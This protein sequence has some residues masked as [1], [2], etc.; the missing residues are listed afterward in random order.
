MPG[1]VRPTADPESAPGPD[2]GGVPL[3]QFLLRPFVLPFTLLLGVG[4]AVLYGVTQNDAALQ[5]VLASQERAQLID[6]LTQQVSAME[7]AERGFVITGQDAFL[8][9]F[10]DAQATFQAT[11]FALQDL[12]V[13]G[14]Q[15]ENLGRVEAAV[16]RWMEQAA[17]PEIQARRVSATRAAQL[18]GTGQGRAILDE[19]REGLRVMTR[20]ETIRLNDATR[21]SHSMLESVRWVT[22]LGL[23]LSITLLILT[24]YRVTR[25]VSRTLGALNAGA[26]DIAAGQYERR[27]PRTPVQELTRL[28]ATFDRMA[29][30]VQDRESD[31]T[32][33]AQA[34]QTSNA[35]LERSNRELEQFAYVA[36]H[37]LQEPLRTIGS[38]TELLARRYRGQLDERADQYIAFTTSA[39]HRM[40]SL[41]QDLLA[42]SRVRQA[43]RVTVPVNLTGL[44]EQLLDDLHTQ[45]QVTGAQVQVGPLPTVNSNPE[46]L[47]HALQNLIGN[48]L[49][50]T[51]PGE[52]AHVQVSAT[53]DG[54]RW[55]LHVQDHGIGIAPEY[56]ERIFGVFQRLHGIDEY[57]GSGIGLAVTRSA[58]EQMGGTL[59]VD[60]TPGLGSTFHLALPITPAPALGG[61]T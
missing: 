35:H 6:M 22:V 13:T 5:R 10:L 16:K 34:L 61:P 26:Q 24:G 54:H 18:V 31:L 46:L 32:R 15:R 40:K 41:I 59:W 43:A 51:R 14:L 17:Q 7:N 57:T 58:A 2:P 48:A 56:H 49:K 55:V 11:V 47:R 21:A 44:V 50:F 60:S 38:Y 4:V 30:A 23:I 45:I 1:A 20:N 52:P 33:A 42:Y 37:D 12:T 29:Q 36:S 8:E 9:P 28:G 19:A 3:R 27:M 39:T 53:Q 25:T